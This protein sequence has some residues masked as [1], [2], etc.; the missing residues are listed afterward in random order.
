MPAELQ[1]KLMAIPETE[2]AN[3]F[4]RYRK[5]YAVAASV[6]AVVL[7]G[8]PLLRLIDV[9]SHT[10]GGWAMRLIS[11]SRGALYEVVMPRVS[12]WIEYVP[13]SLPQITMVA[14]VLTLATITWAVLREPANGAYVLPHQS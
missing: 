5:V 6:A 2:T 11:I 14:M 12:P 10:A 13:F 3:A 8:G 4:A 9:A 1:A 7:V